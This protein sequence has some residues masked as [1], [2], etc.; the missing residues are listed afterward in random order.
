MRARTAL[1]N[2]VHS[3]MRA[4]GTRVAPPTEAHDWLRGGVAI[5]GSRLEP[6]RELCQENDDD[7]ALRRRAE[8]P[9]RPRL[10]HVP[11]IVVTSLDDAG[12]C[13]LGYGTW[14]P[15]Q[16]PPAGARL[17]PGCVRLAHPV[18]SPCG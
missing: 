5:D 11:P 12:A 1:I 6:A 13:L 8:A 9:T 18:A 3:P 10:A 4:C 16:S 7:D 14:M 2:E 17:D 15:I